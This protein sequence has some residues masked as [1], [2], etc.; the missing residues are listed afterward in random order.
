MRMIIELP[1][2]PSEYPIERIKQYKM[3]FFHFS[4][5]NLSI[6]KACAADVGMY[7][8]RA[9]KS[10]DV[11]ICFRVAQSRDWVALREPGNTLRH[12]ARKS[13]SAFIR[14]I[15][16]WGR[17]VGYPY[18]KTGIRGIYIYWVDSKDHRIKFD[19][20]I[21]RFPFLVCMFLTDFHLAHIMAAI[22]LAAA[23]TGAFFTAAVALVPALFF[24]SRYLHDDRNAGLGFWKT[25]EL[26]LIHYLANAVFILAAGF[27]GILNRILLVPSVIFRPNGPDKYGP[28]KS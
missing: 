8:V 15:W 12:K 17:Y 5:N 24:F 26:S 11:D 23:L 9:K 1:G 22:A 14:Q 10:E 6:R 16:G 27:G 3:G 18:A 21:K 13:F 4:N 20:E 2:T 19:I 7:D 25:V 28:D